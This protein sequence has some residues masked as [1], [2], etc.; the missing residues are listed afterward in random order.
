MTSTQTAGS[1]ALY[2]G[3]FNTAQPLGIDRGNYIAI[4]SNNPAAAAQYAVEN[5]GFYLV[6]ADSDGRHYLAGHGLDPYSLVYTP[7]EQ[8][9]VDHISYVVRDAEDLLIAEQRLA[10]L[11]VKTEPIAH[12][13]LWR[14]GPALR[15]ANP[16]GQTIELTPG[17]LV[18]VPMAALVAE[19][20]S[21]PAPISF[22]HTIVRA[23]DVAAG[24]EFSSRVMGLK[25][26]ARIVAPDGIPVLGFF[27]C[28][29]L[30]HCYGVAR[31]QYNGL[32]HMQFTVK[33]PLAVHAAFEHMKQRGKVELIWGPLRHGAGHNVVF[34]F[35]DYTGHIVEYSAEEEIILND[36]TYAPR[37]WPITDP[38]AADEWNLSHV[39]EAMM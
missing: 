15:F 18:D 20:Q 32:H 2:A 26:S 19:P 3:P 23:L 31:S 13:P 27:R 10:E 11:G 24:Y 9:K 36:A 5:M 21:T 22:D 39:P 6:H 12:S 7:G 34:Y 30:Y 38:R 33:N 14:H 8:G 28:H 17:V 35:R 25:E 29:T 4:Q 37:V 1:P 16:S